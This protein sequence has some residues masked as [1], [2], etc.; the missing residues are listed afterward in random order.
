[1]TTLN[2]GLPPRID[3]R[4]KDSATGSYPAIARIGDDSRTGRS[5]LSY[6][7]TNT[8]LFRRKKTGL[9][10][11]SNVAYSI[12][13]PSGSKFADG[14]QT[15]IITNSD[16][17]KGIADN[18]INFYKTGEPL[19]PFNESYRPEQSQTSSFYLTGTDPSISSLGFSGKL[20]SKTQLRFSFDINSAIKMNETSA[21]MYYYNRDTKTFNLVGG[22]DALSEPSASNSTML[23][24]RDCKLFNAFG[25]P[26]ISGS[27][28]NTLPVYTIGLSVSEAL[29]RTLQFEQ[30]QSLLLNSN[31]EAT[32]SQI[33]Y[34]SGTIHSP[35]LLEK[36]VIEM[37]ISASSG[38]FDDF[39]RIATDRSSTKQ[40]DSGGPAITVCLMNQLK[41]NRRELILSA[42]IIPS[43]D[44]MSSTYT[45]VNSNEM[46]SG[47]LSFG[48]P[49]SVI[50]SVGAHKV[51]LKANAANVNY[52]ISTDIQ[53]SLGN[54]GSLISEVCPYGRAMSPISPSGRSYFGKEFGFVVPSETTPKYNLSLT[55]TAGNE[56][57]DIYF[58]EKQDISPYLL[59]PDDKLIFGV[60]KYRPIMSDIL[61]ARGT[62][63]GS[64]D[65]WIDTGNINITLY[66]CQIRTDE[67][68]HDT[69]N[70]NLTSNAIH[71]ALHYDN[72]VVDQFDLEP[73]EAFSGSYIEE[74]FTGSMTATAFS[75]ENGF[76][77]GQRGRRV[78]IVQK[79]IV[80]DIQNQAS[81]YTSDIVPITSGE[82]RTI[83]L[84]IPGFHRN[85]ALISEDERYYDTL[86]P[87][88]DQIIA[89]NG[90]KPAAD[91][92]A[93]IPST[94]VFY[95]VGRAAGNN[96]AADFYDEDWDFL[97]PFESKYSNVS[98]TTAP[99]REFET[100]ARLAEGEIGGGTLTAV[101]SKNVG[102]A[103]E[104]NV[105]NHA[106]GGPDADSNGYNLDLKVINVLSQN[107]SGDPTWLAASD[108]KVS[109][110]LYG[111][112]DGQYNEAKIEYESAGVGTG[113]FYAPTRIVA[114]GFKYGILNTNKE[115]SK[116]IFRRDRYGHLR[117]ML[118]QRRDSKFIN[119]KSFSNSGSPVKVNFIGP[120]GVLTDGEETFSNNVSTECTSSLPYFD[121]QG[122]SRG[123]LPSTSLILP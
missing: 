59:L 39:T 5:K 41:S 109:L 89:L 55:P 43:T 33:I 56:Q 11:T 95:L 1:M 68:F 17:I 97:F 53:D 22:V 116:C 49:A 67:E 12:G 74:Y 27:N 115:N 52:V 64:H 9:G 16:V 110:A 24:G 13:L 32:G 113:N 4:I 48:T 82:N 72:P 93:E 106:P 84:S 37:P 71:E 103:R 77:N 86:L 7:D 83:Q 98:R 70:Q 34:L 44:N 18:F 75:A 78:S 26:Q 8:I 2:K 3:V 57:R 105:L 81:Q 101:L 88:A 100:T 23:M 50:P 120:G 10:E 92:S 46:A 38:W 54:L 114:R 30:T 60:S 96:S 19:T 85:I 25:L 90:G 117:D 21:S 47:F 118:E 15:D 40:A 29:D 91:S 14:F 63:T 20:A 6:D 122:R 111:I 79:D 112:G 36:A 69:L 104:E 42:T 99:F 76:L 65:V 61:A 73:K 35:F 102:V 31:F 87:R 58:H 80:N 28:S 119:D 62:L 51:S 94:F 107:S 123:P 66:G 45:A 121:N 108:N